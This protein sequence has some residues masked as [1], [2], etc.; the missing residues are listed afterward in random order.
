MGLGQGPG[1]DH[2]SDFGDIFAGYEAVR[3]RLPEAGPGGACAPAR[4]LSEIA[5]GF[6]IFL[7]DAFGVLNVGDGAIPGAVERVHA[8]RDAGKRVLVVSN[9]AG[10]P[11]AKLMEKYDR[12]GFGFA[13]E[14][15]VTSRKALLAALTG[16]AGRHW[17]VMANPDLGR[18]DLEGLDLRFLGD[19]PADY[20][21]AEGFLLIGSAIWTE[22]RQDRLVRALRD[23]PRPVLVGN[24]DLAA[25]RENGASREP[26][27]WAH[28]LADATGVAPRFHGKPFAD[29]FDL[30]FDRLG[31]R[32]GRR[33]LMVGDALHTDVLGAQ[34]AG[35]AS[36]LVTGHG[37]LKGRDV[38]GAIAASGIRPDFVVETT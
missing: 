30:A 9:A 25:P 35:V 13:P 18:A 32:P 36:A 15:V 31:H 22:A 8:L 37:L 28:A 34:V 29:I 19:D 21:A 24:P 5:D 33:A 10:F 11:H 20:E 23:R 7:L 12:L 26:G 6:D 3:A 1:R 38:A 16:E 27:H 14:D 2:L 17:G 4:D